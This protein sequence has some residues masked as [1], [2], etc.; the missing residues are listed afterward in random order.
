MQ[1]ENLATSISFIMLVLVS[2]IAFIFI[3]SAPAESLAQ[4]SLPLSSAK[5]S[6]HFVKKWGSEGSGEGQFDVPEGIAADSSGK[7]YVADTNNHRIQKFDSNGNFITEWGSKGSGD[8]EFDGLEGIAADSSGKVYVAD[9][10]NHRIQKFDSNGNF[11][12]EWGSKGSG[13]GEFYSPSGVAVDSSGDVCVTDTSN[14]RIQKFDS[15]GNF[16]TKW[17]P[18]ETNEGLFTFPTGIAVDSSNNVYVT[19]LI[20]TTVQKFDSNGNFIKALGSKA[21]GI[22]HYKGIALDLSGNVYRIY[23]HG[24]QKFD[25]NGIP[26][27]VWGS[28]GTGDGQFDN[29]NSIDVDSS[30]KVYVMDVGNNRVQVFAQDINQPPSITNGANDKNPTSPTINESTAIGNNIT[31]TDNT[32]FKGNVSFSTM[33]G[34]NTTSNSTISKNSPSTTTGNTTTNNENPTPTLSQPAGITDQA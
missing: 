7:V 29:P 22:N 11:I 23:Q 12:T 6:Y 28:Y 20:K 32:H 16:I 33:P 14:N 27:T 17:S 13:D 4:S 25:S 24:V 8:G 21:S 18:A 26:V 15:N 34:N 31:L 10:N 9:T 19:S 1:K 5:E 3:N 2:L 30:G